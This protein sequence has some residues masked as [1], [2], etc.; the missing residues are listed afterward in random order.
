MPRQED[1]NMNQME[2]NLVFVSH[3]NDDSDEDSSEE[4]SSSIHTFESR[5]SPRN[6]ELPSAENTAKDCVASNGVEG[7]YLSQNREVLANN[8][9]DDTEAFQRQPN[10]TSTNDEATAIIPCLQFHDTNNHEHQV[11]VG[12][13]GQMETTENHFPEA[14]NSIVSTVDG[15][16]TKT[17]DM[18]HE[19]FEMNPEIFSSEDVNTNHSVEPILIVP[20]GESQSTLETGLPTHPEWTEGTDASLTMDTLLMNVQPIMIEPLSDDSD[21]DD[22]MDY[23]SGNFLV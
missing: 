6:K 20:T 8:E 19:D 21:M 12:S 15:T 2:P 16:A 4:N 10:V 18:A 17:T 9:A 13:L 23:Q 11:S 3:L 7:T 14:E 1:V 5:K 22:N